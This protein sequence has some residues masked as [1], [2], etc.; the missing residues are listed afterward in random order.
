MQT[1]KDFF[2]IVGGLLLLFLN[3]HTAFAKPPHTLP[4]SELQIP[5]NG[6]SQQHHLAQTAAGE[7]ILSW[8]ETDGGS[9]TAKFAVLEQQGWSMPLTVAKVEGKLADPPVVLGLSDGSLAAAWM[10]YVKDSPDRYAA[11]I[12]LARSIDGGLSWSTPL[13]PYGAD[14]RIYDAQMSL[15]AL[16]DA[17]LALVWT[18]MR[19]AS[20]DPAADKKT[21][22][23][24]LMASVID[25]NWRAS[26][27]LV[28]D[29]DVCSCCRSYTDA[30][31]EQLVTVYRDHAVGEIRDISA[32][33]WQPGGNPQITN[34]HADGWVIGGCPSNGPSIDLTPTAGVAAWFTAADGKGRVKVAFSS[35]KGA[36]FNQPI[37]LDADAS[38]YAN[39]L[40]LDDGSALVSWRGR[41]GP[42]DELR[43]AKVTT[44]GRISRE[45]TLY[46]GS[47]PK[48]PSKYLAMACVGKQAFVAWTDPVQKKVRLVSLTID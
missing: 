2:T 12:Y 9:S 32:V 22:R 35:D 44:D 10:P 13:K 24:Q 21:N 15:A 8:V 41:N 48:W 47:F 30:Q 33:R 7:L 28:L 38:G 42:E 16:P 3:A 45:T 6:V 25:K 39:A 40:L 46:R 26:P 27:E 14:A 23:Y 37:E 17:R 18:D 43:V 20:H 11:D 34:V 29:D 36:Q 1:I 4:M 19:N 31:G 5:A